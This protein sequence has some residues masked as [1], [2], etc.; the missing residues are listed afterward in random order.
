MYLLGVDKEP[1]D[2]IGIGAGIVFRWVGI[3]LLLV[4]VPVVIFSNGAGAL[5]GWV[6]VIWGLFAV[7]WL[8]FSE[9]IAKAADFRPLSYFTVF[10]GFMCMYGSWMSAK[11]DSW[12]FEGGLILAGLTCWSAF[13]AMRFKPMW[14]KI[15]GFLFAVTGIWFT[16]VAFTFLWP[17]PAA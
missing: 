6:A 7:I 12:K 5:T 15:C 4:G 14:M 2:K 11:I 16:Y 13:G 9:G 3:I 10:V 1:A 8:G 17:L